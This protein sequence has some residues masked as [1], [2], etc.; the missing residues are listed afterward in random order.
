MDHEMKPKTG[1]LSLAEELWLHILSFLSCKDILRCT[2]VCKALQQTYLSS[3]KLQYIVELSG[4]RLS[5]PVPTKDDH[6]PTSERLQLLRDRAHAWFKVDFHS[7]ETVFIPEVPGYVDKFVA[8]GHL[9]LWDAH[10]DKAAIIPILPKPSQQRIKRNWSPGTLRPLHIPAANLDVLMDPA[11]NLIASAYVIY[12][13]NAEPGHLARETLHVDLIPLDGSIPLQAAGRTLIGLPEN[14]NEITR[15]SMA[16]LK[17]YGKYIALYR[18]VEVYSTSELYT[19][20]PR[21]KLQIWDRQH[22]TTSNS[23]LSR[24]Y[25]Y[26]ADN[27]VNDFCFLGNNRLLVAIDMLELYSFEDM[28]QTPQLLARFVMP[29]QL[30]EIE[31]ILS[32][33]DIAHTPQMPT[34][35]T[36]DLRHQLLCLNASCATSTAQYQVYVIS[37]RIFFDFD[38]TM[39]EA[40]EIPWNH[41][42]PSNARF[43]QHPFPPRIRISGNRV[44]QANFFGWPSIHM[45]DFS[46]LAVTNRQGLG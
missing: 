18:K 39:I 33:D 20:C 6:T 13:D 11:Q 32:T 23:V 14:E 15:T 2:S 36:P 19:S 27:N 24:C 37:T 7:S 29:F 41:W 28:S 31:C 40:P 1:F 25:S 38:G 44:L 3:S 26:R 5:F 22:S 12:V 43:F 34:A 30:L 42:G 9:Y 4:Q 8:D 16:K 45:M 17:D 46:P 35:C 10:E 21:W